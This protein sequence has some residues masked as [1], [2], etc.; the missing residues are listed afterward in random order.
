M[1]KTELVNAL[2]DAG[3]APSD[4]QE[5]YA[6]I[7]AARKQQRDKK[8]EEVRDKLA[9]FIAEYANLL[10]GESIGDP[11]PAEVKAVKSMLKDNESRIKEP[12][13]KPAKS[14]SNKELEDAVS[15]WL[16]SI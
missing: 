16:R 12:S 5:E 3:L 1:T 10:A 8:I 7:S 9:Y 2:W 11:T 15:A 4:L 6:R 14:K 13:A